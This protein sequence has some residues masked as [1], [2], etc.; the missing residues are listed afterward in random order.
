MEYLIIDN[1]NNTVTIKK[2]CP[3]DIVFFAINTFKG[4]DTKIIFEDV[5]VTTKL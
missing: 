1:E 4:T 5:N 3:I 2:E